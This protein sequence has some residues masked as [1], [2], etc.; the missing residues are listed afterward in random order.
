MIKKSPFVERNGAGIIVEY[1]KK[2]F[3]IRVFLSKNEVTQGKPGMYVF[4]YT[5]RL[6]IPTQYRRT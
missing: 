1:S 5:G 6:E 3:V 2:V 4:M